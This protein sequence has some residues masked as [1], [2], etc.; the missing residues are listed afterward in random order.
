[1]SETL[2][3]DGDLVWRTNVELS[4]RLWEWCAHRSVR[5]VYA[6]SAATYGDGCAGSTTIQRS[7]QS[8]SR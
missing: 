5:F 7:H 8:W 1:V 3:T 4:M 6:S 2:A